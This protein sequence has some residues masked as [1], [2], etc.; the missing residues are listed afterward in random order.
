MAEMLLELGKVRIKVAPKPGRL[1]GW[2]NTQPTAKRREI[3]RKIA[4]TC[5]CQTAF[6][7]LNVIATA[8]ITSPETRKKA[9]SDILWLKRQPV[10]GL[11]RHG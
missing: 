11:G 3:V 7:R 8:R 10:C 2:S 9:Q 4:R 6:R 1:R 5:G